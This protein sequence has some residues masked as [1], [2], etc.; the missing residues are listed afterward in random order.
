MEST[1]YIKLKFA[2]GRERWFTD[3]AVELQAAPAIWI[4]RSMAVEIVQEVSMGD[5]ATISIFSPHVE[6][7]KF[8]NA[9]I[10]EL[11]ARRRDPRRPIRRSDI[12]RP[13]GSARHDPK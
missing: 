4:Q 12:C 8:E 2:N 5:P 6:K 10:P 13:P 11:L 9:P 1:R 3:T 7:S